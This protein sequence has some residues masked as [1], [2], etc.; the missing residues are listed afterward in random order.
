MHQPYRRIKTGQYSLAQLPAAVWTKTG[1]TV[2]L[3]VLASLLF[4]SLNANA[5]DA[6]SGDETK[7]V[8]QNPAP[9]LSQNAKRSLLAAQLGGLDSAG[10]M[11]VIVKLDAGKATE[12][13]SLM[14]S[15]RCATSRQRNLPVRSGSLG[16]QS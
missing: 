13:R 4:A 2:L 12:V 7:V 8:W 1:R 16:F 5:G 10:Y 14:S 6:P 11:L 3:L 9:Q 15:V